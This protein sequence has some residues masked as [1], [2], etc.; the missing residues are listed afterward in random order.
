VNG[1]EEL[2]QLRACTRAI[3]LSQTSEFRPCVKDIRSIND[4][5]PGD[6]HAKTV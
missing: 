6:A 1:S 2:P 5:V 3:V 4:E